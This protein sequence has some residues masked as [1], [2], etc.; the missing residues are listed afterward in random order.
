MQNVTLRLRSAQRD[1]TTN[2]SKSENAMPCLHVIESRNQLCWTFGAIL[3]GTWLVYDN[4][5]QAIHDPL[6]FDASARL[7]ALCVRAGTGIAA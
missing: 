5:K 3:E 1:F 6:W 4:E 7:D 2:I